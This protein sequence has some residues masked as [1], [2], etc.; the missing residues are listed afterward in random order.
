MRYMKPEITISRFETED[1]ITTSS[2]AGNVF[3]TLDQTTAYSATK[4]VDV[5]K[6]MNQE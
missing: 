6:V 5:G 3:N 2:N 1:I 4:S